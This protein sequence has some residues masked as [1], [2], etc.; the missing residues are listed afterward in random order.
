MFLFLFLTV[1]EGITQNWQ[2]QFADEIMQFRISDSLNPPPQ[3]AILFAGSSS[4]TMWTDVQDYFPGYPIINRGF[5]GSTLLDLIRYA[6]E[7]IYPY[8]AK[9]IVI[10]CG[11]NDI[12]N[13]DTV[14]GEVVLSRFKTLFVMIRERMPDVKITYISMKPSP[15]RWKLSGKMITGNDAIKEFLSKEKNTSFVNVWDDM[16]DSDKQPDPSLFLE[17]MLHMNRRGYKIWQ[18]KIEPEL[19][20]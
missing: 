5:G 17:D 4:F 9:Q 7:M 20:R 14:S 2:D 19:G 11:E 3:N 18:K 10:Y 8:D 16:L 12:A 1:S 15:S 6:E 13:S